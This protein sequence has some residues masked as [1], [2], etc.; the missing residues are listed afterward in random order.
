[1]P[2]RSNWPARS[3]GSAKPFSAKAM[4]GATTSRRDSVPWRSSTASRPSTVPGTPTA[5][6]EAV[7]RPSITLPSSSWYMSRCALA[8]AFSRWSFAITRPSAS[9]NTMKP[10]PPRLP[11]E[12]CVTA[13][14]K[15]VATAA[16][17]ALPP[18]LRMSMPTWEA[19][20]ER[21]ATT[22][23]WPRTTCAGSAV[24]GSAL[25][26]SSA[27][28]PA[29]ASTAASGSAQ[30]AL[31]SPAKRGLPRGFRVLYMA[32]SVSPRKKGTISTVWAEVQSP[33][34]AISATP[35]GIGASAGTS[36]S[37]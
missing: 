13:S 26:A 25:G 34:S 3:S 5:R 19:S 16:S 20:G 35:S 17:T 8:G 15:P 23:F 31:A 10:P 24:A 28:T 1:M 18:R 6:C 4:A 32:C 27:A 9:R 7:E 21:E 33:F 11:A 29:V 2:W 22:P 30:S 36:W 14:A 37:R 12:G